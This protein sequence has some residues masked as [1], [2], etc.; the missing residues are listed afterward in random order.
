MGL[1]LGW[2]LRKTP[3][4]A[5]SVGPFLSD[6]GTELQAQSQTLPTST[7]PT[8][9]F[10][11]WSLALLSTLFLC[12]ALDTKTA[13]GPRCSFPVGLNQAV[14]LKVFRPF[15]LQRFLE[16][17]F[18]RGNFASIK[19]LNSLVPSSEILSLYHGRF[20][21]KYDCFLELEENNRT[22]QGNC[23]D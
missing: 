16:C 6:P 5:L 12:S 14:S 1:D 15:T 8:K 21:S 11:L 3:K 10:T 22:D 2:H 13:S 4:E 7:I 23:D 19:M 9:D 20:Y 18:C 17:D